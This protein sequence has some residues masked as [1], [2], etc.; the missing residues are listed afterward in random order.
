MDEAMLSVRGHR[1]RGPLAA[2]AAAL[3]AAAAA[4]CSQYAEGAG[5]RA[6]PDVFLFLDRSAFDEDVRREA[7]GAPRDPAAFSRDLGKRLVCLDQ[8][9][10]LRVMEVV[11][12]GV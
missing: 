6:G 3:V 1:G 5:Y 8:G 4:G 11:P 7:A 9:S 10:E 2:I 12:G